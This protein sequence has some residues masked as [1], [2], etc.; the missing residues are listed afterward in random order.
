MNP[1]DLT[2]SQV[3]DEFYFN[4][5][6][7]FEISSSKQKFAKCVIGQ[8]TDIKQFIKFSKIIPAFTGLS[9]DDQILLLRGNC[10]QVTITHLR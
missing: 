10:I 9:M 3:D 8:V 2:P 4:R 6:S 5:R 1:E 7:Q